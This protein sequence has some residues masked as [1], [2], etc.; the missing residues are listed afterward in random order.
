[1]L[2]VEYL[3]DIKLMQRIRELQGK[4][5]KHFEILFV[6]PHKIVLGYVTKYMF[7]YNFVEW[8]K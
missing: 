2:N 8:N 5:S 3:D 4:P 6:T 1:M 7:G